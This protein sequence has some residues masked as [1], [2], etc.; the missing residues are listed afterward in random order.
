MENNLHSISLL[1]FLFLLFCL[2]YFGHIFAFAKNR[3]FAISLSLHSFGTPAAWL[4]SFVREDFY[5]WC[6]YTPL[7][8]S[9][10]SFCTEIGS[11]FIYFILLKSKYSSGSIIPSSALKSI[12]LLSIKTCQYPLSGFGSILE[13]IEFKIISPLEFI[14]PYFSVLKS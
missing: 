12:H 4:Q 1:L 10:N 2:F 9:K 13:Q 7:M 3:L 5:H 14:K 11:Y 8:L 6:P